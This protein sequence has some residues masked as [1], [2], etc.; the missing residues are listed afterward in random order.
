MPRRIRDGHAAR[1]TRQ[2]GERLE[3]VAVGPGGLLAA[4]RA[5]ELGPAVRLEVSRRTRRGRTRRAGRRRPRRRARGRSI[6]GCHVPGSSAAN[7][8]TPME[9]WINEDMTRSLRCR[10]RAHRGDNAAVLVAARRAARQARRPRRR[11]SACSSR[12]ALGFGIT[13]LEFATGQDSYLNKSDQVYK[14]NV[15]YQDLFGGQAMLTARHDGRGPHRRR[16]VHAGERR[17]V[18]QAIDDAAD[19]TAATCIGVVTPLTALEFN[20]DLVPS[21]DGDP[22]QSVAGK[23]LL[24]AHAERDAGA[25]GARPRAARTPAETLERLNAD[26]GRGADARQPRVG[27]LPAP[28]QPGRDPQ[29][30]A[31]RSSPT[32]GTRRSSPGSRATRRSRTRARPPSSCRTTAD[33]ARLRRTPTIVTTGAP[34]LLKDIN[35][36]LTGGMLTLGAIAVAIMVVILLVL[37]RRALAAAAARRRPHRR[38][39][40]LRP[41]RLPR[42]P[43]DDRH[44]RRPPGDARHRHRLRDP[45][46]RRASRRRSSST[47][48]TTRSRR[49]PATS[50]RRC[51]SSRSTRSSPSP[52][53]ASPR[54]R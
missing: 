39:L 12:S 50:A 8:V 2:R 9:S 53:C 46:A 40:G 52:R 4:R 18:R 34:V 5:A 25:R 43:A 14:D 31:R 44:H 35:D 47:A 10:C 54:C 51:W 48:P 26:P 45:D 7:D 17:A 41:R 30:A 28:R 49:P 42:H 20:D 37:L 36:Y 27:R 22:T 19:A 38:G 1:R 33:E 32:T 29:V 3:P 16:A 13:K 15:A 23:V 6:R 21:P 11:S 24:G